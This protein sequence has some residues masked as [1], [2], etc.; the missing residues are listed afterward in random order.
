LGDWVIESASVTRQSQLPLSD[1]PITQFLNLPI[2]EGP[3]VLS[4]D[5]CREIEAYL[6]RKNDGHLI[7][8]VGPS[9]D[10]V[11]GWASL[12]IPLKIACAGIDRY[13]ERAK[14]KV[15]RRRPVR[16]DFCEPDV[17]AAY[18][19]WRRAVGLSA[20]S[21]PSEETSL[22]TAAEP[23]PRSGS[24]RAHLERVLL[25]LSSARA[26]GAIGPAFDGLIDRAAREFDVVRSDA[27]G[28]RGEGRKQLLERLV[29]LDSEL[30]RVAHSGLD[31]ASAAALGRQ[32]DEELAP[33]RDRM[34]AEA[35]ARARKA[36]VDRLIRER[37]ALP[38]I[39]FE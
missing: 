26:S 34:P 17:L 29:E 33:F 11:Q 37:C 16:I 38:T 6:C 23:R 31:E 3:Q 25:R 15:A 28:L 30:L 22:A 14:K 4:T 27:R 21:S 32:A 12:G 9:F 5:Y 10:L 24:L 2:P 18:D 7:R 1:Y 35:L 13:C 36:A 20:P 39:A 19:E 8:V